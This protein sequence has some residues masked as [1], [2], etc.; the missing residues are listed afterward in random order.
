ME[1]WRAR[2]SLRVLSSLSL[3]FILLIDVVQ[4]R[5]IEVM[6]A[7]VIK[8]PVTGREKIK[9]WRGDGFKISD[10]DDVWLKGEC[11]DLHAEDTEILQEIKYFAGK[12]NM[13]FPFFLRRVKIYQGYHCEPQ[14]LIPDATVNLENLDLTES[15]QKR[16]QSPE[17]LNYA[18]AIPY[19]ERAEG[20]FSI[21]H[22]AHIENLDNLPERSLPE[23]LKNWPTP[24]DYLRFGQWER[25]V[26]KHNRM[27]SAHRGREYID[28]IAAH[29]KPSEY[30]EDASGDDGD[31]ED[32]WSELI[33][34]WNLVPYDIRGN[35]SL[36]LEMD[37]TRW[38]MDMFYESP[39]KLP[40]E[41]PEKY[42]NWQLGQSFTKK[43]RKLDDWGYP[44]KT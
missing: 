8:D 34:Y 21:G 23:D 32:W 27:I 6:W 25:A 39:Y 43:E 11:E 37:Y 2:L 18:G 14:N 16:W 12:P 15:E 31:V 7:N 22:N 33:G 19:G 29:M 44:L 42:R 24:Q 30:D 20:Y 9:R 4:P 35:I 26:G 17:W 40:M 10:T 5:H 41:D 36:K 13:E 3:L 28:Q 1:C 38:H